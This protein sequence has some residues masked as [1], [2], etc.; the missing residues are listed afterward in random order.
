MKIELLPRNVQSYIRTGVAITSVGQCVEELVLNSLDAGATCIAVRIDL[1]SFKVQVVDNG[2]GISRNEMELLGNRFCTSKCHSLED[3]DNLTHHGYRGEAVASIRDCC[4]L[5]KITTREQSSSQTYC[6]IFREGK[7][8]NVVES[9]ESR[10][11]L[12]TTVTVHEL[13]INFPVRQKSLNKTHELER[14]REILESIALI[15]PSV[16]FSLRND[17]TGQ[18]V[19]QTRKGT[20]TGAIASQLYGPAK[21]S[22]L[23]PVEGFTGIYR[24]TGF[25]GREGHSRKNLQFV[26]VN[27]RIVKKT[28]VHK[29]LSQVLM[30]LPTLRPKVKLPEGSPEFSNHNKY[31][32]KSPPKF[33][34]VYPVFILQI[35]CPV[36]EYDITFE[37]AKTMV[38]FKDWDTLVSCVEDLAT[39]F[40]GNQNGCLKESRQIQEQQ[41]NKEYK[42]YNGDRTC[43]VICPENMKDT[44]KSKTATR[45]PSVPDNQFKTPQNPD[46]KIPMN[47]A[48]IGLGRKAKHLVV[49]GNKSFDSSLEHDENSDATQMSTESEIS[50]SIDAEL[51]LLKGKEQNNNFKAGVS[52][53]ESDMQVHPGSHKGMK[54]NTELLRV[55]GNKSSRTVSETNGAKALEDSITNSA[56]SLSWYK[57]SIGKVPQPTKSVSVD[58]SLKKLERI[59]ALQSASSR[60]SCLQKFR[61]R[62]RNN[63]DVQQDESESC[64]IHT[65]NVKKLMANQA[66]SNVLKVD[67]SKPDA[68]MTDQ[69]KSLVPIQDQ[70]NPDVFMREQSK[71]NIEA[72]KLVSNERKSNEFFTSCGIT[73]ELHVSGNVEERNRKHC[74]HPSKPQYV[75]YKIDLENMM[76]YQMNGS[77]VMNSE[78]ECKSLDSPYVDLTGLDF[79]G[80]EQKIKMNRLHVHLA[81]PLLVVTNQ[82]KSDILIQDHINTNVLMGEQ[83]KPR[84]QAPKQCILNEKKSN[85]FC[86]SCGETEELGS[87]IFQF[88]SNAFHVSSKYDQDAAYGGGDD[89]HVS[90]NLEERNRTH[91]SQP[92]EPQYVA[93]AIDLENMMDYQMNGS[94]VMNSEVKCNIFDSQYVDLIGQDANGNEQ[95]MKM[96]RKRQAIKNGMCSSAKV[97]RLHEREFCEFVNN[98][99]SDLDLLHCGDMYEI[100]LDTVSADMSHIDWTSNPDKNIQATVCETRVMNDGVAKEVDINDTSVRNGRE[101]QSS[102]GSTPALTNDHC[103]QAFT[104]SPYEVDCLHTGCSGE[105]VS[106]QIKEQENMTPQSTGFSPVLNLDDFGLSPCTDSEIKDN[107]PLRWSAGFFPSKQDVESE[108]KYSQ[109]LKMDE[110]AVEDTLL[111]D[112]LLEISVQSDCG[113]ESEVAN[114]C[115]ERNQD[116]YE[117]SERFLE[118]LSCE[119]I[120]LTQL[121]ENIENYKTSGKQNCTVSQAKGATN[122]FDASNKNV[123]TFSDLF[124]TQ[125]SVFNITDTQQ[126]FKATSEDMVSQ[127]EVLTGT[128][129]AFSEAEWENGITEID[130]GVVMQ[131]KQ[132]E[133]KE[134]NLNA[135]FQCQNGSANTIQNLNEK[136]NNYNEPGTLSLDS[137]SA[138]NNCSKS[139]SDHHMHGNIKDTHDHCNASHTLSASEGW[140]AQKWTNTES[141]A[142]RSLLANLDSL[143]KS[144]GHVPVPDF[145]YLTRPGEP[146]GITCQFS[147]QSFNNVKVLGQL[148]NKFIACLLEP[149]LDGAGSSKDSADH[150]LLLLVDQHAAHERIRLEILTEEAFVKGKKGGYLVPYEVTP[151]RQLLFTENEIW[152]LSSFTQEYQRLGITF[153]PDS[154][155]TI[156]VS[157]VPNCLVQKAENADK[158][159]WNTI[160]VFMSTRGAQSIVP[161]TVHKVLCQQACHGAIKFGDS[162][163]LDE[164]HHLIRDLSLCDMPFQCAHGRPSIT[165]LVQLSSLGPFRVKPRRKPRL[166]KLRMAK[167]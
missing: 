16:S 74:Y 38:E 35:Q 33:S 148:D 39:S 47:K 129:V 95:K 4:G 134:N 88:H 10:P 104:P 142:A 8:I 165:P 41:S 127:P 67:L 9:S 59:V 143:V 105:F 107:S 20:D 51:S 28:R 135:E 66:N 32:F 145:S 141:E 44:L 124:D 17:V 146:V 37:P 3:L 101:K 106:F 113:N 24:L 163:T 102:E 151:P 121:M 110:N 31:V 153:D 103:T 92:S 81:K 99:K 160:K 77:D 140:D 154:S 93:Y 120:S 22:M 96:N 139:C 52:I 119:S 29:I 94:E 144:S 118:N 109:A 161:Q 136:N 162:L 54:I 112:T 79:Y 36:S 111:D 116:S 89:F 56:S 18:V 149:P 46:M 150:A 152:N 130:T 115:S 125:S 30:N 53:E 63:L 82:A 71:P 100:K 156:L 12:G 147:K 131:E 166:D 34:E 137:C 164:C 40:V 60:L 25:L 19:F 15:R 85:E 55:T 62:S 86:T 7:A 128:S 138:L 65:S 64:G 155:T 57:K 69:A 80:S 72:P 126:V 5:L 159:Y 13:F 73:D 167:F 133:K 87:K 78:V 49:N 50:D 1:D 61:N 108:E 122:M 91:C 48:A 90:G 76:D 84:I 21:S 11:S 6:K 2:S 83:E 98:S 43:N 23:L 97:I 70:V 58:E 114:S 123:V 75:A 157:S 68:V 42:E 132:A 45:K 14:V 158:I 27:G 117:N 26:Y